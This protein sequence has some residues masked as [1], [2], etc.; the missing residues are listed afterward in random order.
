M[1]ILI[2]TSAPSFTSLDFIIGQSLAF[3]QDFGSGEAAW[4]RIRHTEGGEAFPAA[5][6]RATNGSA[7]LLRN[8]AVA[9]QSWW[10]ENTDSEG[11]LLTDALAQVPL[12]SILP[13]SLRISQ[14]Q[15]DADNS[16]TLIDKADYKA[17]LIGCIA[18]LRT[19]VGS[20][21]PVVVEQVGRRETDGN[22]NGWDLIRSAQYEVAEEISGVFLTSTYDL[23]L[24]DSVHPTLDGYF[25]LGARSAR[26]LVG[27]VGP[28]R[29]AHNVSNNTLSIPIID[30]KGRGLFKPAVPAGFT[31]HN[32]ASPVVPTSWT[33]FGDTLQVI[34]ATSPVGLTCEY[35]AGTGVGLNTSDVIRETTSSWPTGLNGVNLRGLP[36]RWFPPFTI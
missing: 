23:D 11:T 25:E 9:N 6:V 33:W 27:D 4:L 28:V 36:L 17:A 22:H 1:S 26:A 5:F 13:T 34:F 30:S 29:G 12:R 20:Q 19:E 2:G 24:R 14:G 31:F 8:S 18:A 10:N 21:I 7:M 35:I 3:E 15:Q 32:G 16:N